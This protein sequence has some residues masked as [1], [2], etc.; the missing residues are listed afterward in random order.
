MSINPDFPDDDVEEIP[1]QPKY[2]ISADFSKEN[3][4]KGK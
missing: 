2:S 1:R 4:I 3:I